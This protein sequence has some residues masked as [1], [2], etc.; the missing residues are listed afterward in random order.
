LTLAGKTRS[1]FYAPGS[2]H[3]LSIKLS[4]KT[5]QKLRKK[6]ELDATATAV[7]HDGNGSTHRTTAK[8]TLLRPR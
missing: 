5:F 7:A 6:K 1:F 4:K 8:I 3:K 2:K